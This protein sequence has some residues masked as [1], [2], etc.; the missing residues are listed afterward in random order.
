[1]I[2]RLYN[3]STQSAV[4]Q[5]GSP[6]S[7]GAHF[8]SNGDA[9]VLAHDII[10]VLI[11]S[12]IPAATFQANSR[13]YLDLF[14]VQE[15]CRTISIDCSNLVRRS[16]VRFTCGPAAVKVLDFLENPIVTLLLFRFENAF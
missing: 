2:G 10:N 4:T 11:M 3:G 13:Q 6:S 15:L 7:R 8:G 9:E 12:T 16:T 14:P 1:M 5:T